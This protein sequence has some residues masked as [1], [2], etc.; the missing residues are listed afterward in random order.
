MT[1]RLAEFRP[2]VDRLAAELRAIDGVEVDVQRSGAAVFE[3][4]EFLGGVTSAYDGVVN[5]VARLKGTGGRGAVLIGAHVDSAANAPGAADDLQGVGVAVEAL[6]V[7][8]EARPARDVVV[9]LNAAEEM[10]QLGAHAF[11]T[12]HRWAQDVRFVLNLE[13]MGA[14]GR[15]FVFRCGSS[16]VAGALGGSTALRGSVLAEELFS[17][18]LWRAARTD[19]AEFLR[20]LPNPPR[21]VD[22]AFIDDGS[23]PG[24]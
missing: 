19:Y 18:V 17:A 1:L 10:H 12:Q 16:D 13:S 7:L 20:A 23:G 6:R 15:E 21:G 22:V 5:V 24:R 11:A 9:V 3:H 14:G 2:Q 8:A 4:A